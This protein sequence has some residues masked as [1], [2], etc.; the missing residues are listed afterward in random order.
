LLKSL[1]EQ[2]FEALS[3]AEL[4]QKTLTGFNAALSTQQKYQSL[5]EVAESLSKH[6]D[7]DNLIK[8]ILKRARLI[9]SAE[10]CSLFLV[11]AGENVMFY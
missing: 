10:R 4:F 11:D 9:G 8:F 5:L 6:L 1:A 7:E 2:I 3:N